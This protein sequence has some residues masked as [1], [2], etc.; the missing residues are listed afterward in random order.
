MRKE[1]AL[2]VLAAGMLVVSLSGRAEEPN[3]EA[4]S[5]RVIDCAFRLLRNPDDLMASYL[6]AKSAFK[7]CNYKTSISIIWDTDGNVKEQLGEKI[8]E[9]LWDNIFR[10][11]EEE[12]YMLIYGIPGTNAREEDLCKH[13]CDSAKL[14]L[15]KSSSTA[16]LPDSVKNRRRKLAE[17]LYATAFEQDF[18]PA[19][20]EARCGFAELI[21]ETNPSQA[22]EVYSKAIRIGIET[23]VVKTLQTVIELGKKLHRQ[24]ESRRLVESVFERELKNIGL[25]DLCVTATRN[26]G[27]NALAEEYLKYRDALFD[28]GED[29][30]LLIPR[31]LINRMTDRD[32]CK[33]I[34]QW[35]SLLATNSA[36]RTKMPKKRIMRYCDDGLS[37]KERQTLWPFDVDTFERD[38]KRKM[39]FGQEDG[40]YYVKGEH[41]D[42]D[43]G[44]YQGNVA[45]NPSIRWTNRKTAEWATNVLGRVYR[46][47][48]Q[49][50]LRRMF[51]ADSIT[52]NTFGWHLGGDEYFVIQRID[53]DT[54]F[55]MHD[56]LFVKWMGAGGAVIVATFHAMPRTLAMVAARTVQ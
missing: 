5:R 23:N 7:Q 56:Y 55:E 27:K 13:L 12:F 9:D 6:L 25:L 37:E 45:I 19:S 49:D 50:E 42:Y 38:L 35:K 34:A 40:C 1:F 53:E 44:T 39:V 8:Y 10:F 52:D 11:S 21:Q 30:S 41:N 24:E 36:A 54:K 28:E 16:S 4:V 29:A 31:A 14:L 17:Q 46:R 18:D 26:A 3:D 33:T 32:E 22:F 15:E 48:G 51:D 47:L 2:A 43:E 20:G